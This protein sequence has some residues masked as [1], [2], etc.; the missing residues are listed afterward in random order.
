MHIQRNIPCLT[1]R[2]SGLLV[3]VLV[4]VMMHG[5]RA[6]ADLVWTQ[7][8][9]STLIPHPGA[10]VVARYTPGASDPVVGAGTR[11]THVYARRDYADRVQLE[12]SL[13]WGSAQGPCVALLGEQLDTRSFRGLDARGPILLV[14]RWK[15]SAGGPALAGSPQPLIVRGAVTVWYEPDA[16]H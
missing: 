14:H 4:A 8:P 2:A 13:C 15:S 16:G 7:A 11:I 10:T 3:G 1:V 12:T 5:A 6:A 9:A